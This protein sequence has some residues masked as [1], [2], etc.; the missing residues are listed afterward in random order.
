MLALDAAS[1]DEVWRGQTGRIVRSAPAIGDGLV[2][3]TAYD[4]AYAFDATTGERRRRF[5]ADDAFGGMSS[6]VVDADS[7]SVGA[8]SVYV[9]PHVLL[10]AVDRTTGTARWSV[11]D[12]ELPR[13]LVVDVQPRR[14][15]LWRVVPPRLEVDRSQCPRRA[16]PR[17]RGRAARRGRGERTQPRPRCGRA[18]AS[19]VGGPGRR[20]RSCRYGSVS[21]RCTF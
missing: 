21:T 17:G 8:D 6:P 15:E 13:L 12:E 1:G 5:Q 9:D 19:P 2:Y 3:A 7:V 16:A 20:Q 4:T 11:T 14:E 18:R 10:Y